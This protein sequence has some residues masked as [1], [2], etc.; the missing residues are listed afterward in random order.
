[1]WRFRPTVLFAAWWAWWALRSVRSQLKLA[2]VATSV[3]E[4]PRLPNS[5]GIGVQA[6]LNRTAP[7]CLERALV[8][9][10]W[11][12]AHGEPRDVVIGVITTGTDQVAE[13]HNGFAA[14]A[15]VDGREPSAVDTYVEVHRIAAP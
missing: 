1:M 3:A 11:L 15:W 9:Q 8:S 10:R 13:A 4:P 14:H 6:I 5:A 12:A 2:G 7:T